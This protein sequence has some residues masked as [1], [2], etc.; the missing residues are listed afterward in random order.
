[1]YSSRVVLLILAVVLAAATAAC[2]SSSG[3]KA[4]R[5]VS[6]DMRRTSFEPPSVSARS[7]ETIE[8]RFT[9]DD[10]TTHE[11][12]I[13]NSAAQADHEAEMTG[14]GGHDMHGADNA[15]TV[16]PGK[17]KTLTYAFSSPTALIIGCHEKGHYAAG[18]KMTVA[19]T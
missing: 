15:V 1:V 4:D 10:E 14:G 7:G 8:F 17:T 13:G 11:A 19:I 18:M 16:E 12:Y 2:A 5:T 6:V 3:T 9:N